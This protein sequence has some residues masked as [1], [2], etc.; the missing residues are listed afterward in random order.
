MRPWR[1]R[2]GMPEPGEQCREDR[3]AVS[4]YRYKPVAVL[5]IVVGIGMLVFG[6]V[7]FT[8]VPD[9]NRSSRGEP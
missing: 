4:R 9:D 2:R 3:S 5:G 7:T 6:I 8:R 1:D